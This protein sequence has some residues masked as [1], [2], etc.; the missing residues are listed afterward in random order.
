MISIQSAVG[1]AMVTTAL[2]LLGGCAQK[3]PAPPVV[4]TSSPAPASIPAGSAGADQPLSAA[5]L[6]KVRAYI[7]S[8][9]YLDPHKAGASFPDVTIEVE[10]LRDGTVESTQVVDAD[11]MTDPGFREAA[12]AAQRALLK[13]SRLPLPRDKYEFWKKTSFRFSAAGFVG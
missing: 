13:C 12:E 3:Q 7:A 2:P 10:L 8:C 1:F 6:D 9:W 5:E 11:R 4:A